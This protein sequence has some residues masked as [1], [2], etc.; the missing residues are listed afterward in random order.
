MAEWFKAHAWKAC[1]GS[2]PSGVRIPLPPPLKKINFFLNANYLVAET[3]FKHA[4]YEIL[5]STCRFLDI[6]I[7]LSFM[8]ESSSSDKFS[9]DNSLPAKPILK[10]GNSSLK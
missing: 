1:W 4:L 3:K 5:P 7:I 10:M 2:R 8:F 9:S 6:A